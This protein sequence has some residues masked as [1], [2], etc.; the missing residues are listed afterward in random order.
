[1]TNSRRSGLVRRKGGKMGMI[2]I[3]TA[4]SF[5]ND[6]KIFTAS[7]YGHAH[8]VNKAMTYFNC[9]MRKSINSDHKLQEEG[10]KPEKGFTLE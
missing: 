7:E 1:M 8:C 10:V 6:E 9:L 4:G 2:I 5:G 3:R